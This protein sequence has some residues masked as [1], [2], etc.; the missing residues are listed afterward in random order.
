MSSAK[1]KA[2]RES[3]GRYRDRMRKAGLRLVQLWIPDL[4]APGFAKECR[5]Q[6]IAATSTR[7]VEDDVMSW[8]EGSRDSDGWTG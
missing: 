7:R 6:S 2:A 1:K 8:I 3:V 4:R 5:R